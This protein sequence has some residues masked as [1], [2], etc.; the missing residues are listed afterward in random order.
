M[1][2]I[3]FSNNETLEFKTVSQAKD[4]VLALMIS[5]IQALGIVSDKTD[6]LNHLQDYVASIY[7]SIT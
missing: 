5:G 6:D 1:I 7:K 3:T 2:L 4:Y